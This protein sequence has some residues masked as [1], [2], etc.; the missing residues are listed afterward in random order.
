[1]HLIDKH[2]YPKNFFFAITRDG[3]DGRRSLLLEDRGRGRQ[4]QKPSA[5]AASRPVSSP[6]NHK[7]DEPE[8]VEKPNVSTEGQPTMELEQKITVQQPDQDMEDLSSAMSSLRFV[9]MSVRFGR[10][11]KA[12]FAKR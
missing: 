9:P 4:Q 11:G 5:A 3:I 6:E 1:M 7:G 10:G 8:V 2:M 12:G